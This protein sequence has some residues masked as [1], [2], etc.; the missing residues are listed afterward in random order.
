V[1]CACVRPTP[2]RGPASRAD[3]PRSSVRRDGAGS[4]TGT[5]TATPPAAASC[6][7]R[8]RT[9]EVARCDLEHGKAQLT[10]G[11]DHLLSIIKHGHNLPGV[12]DVPV[13]DLP[14]DDRVLALVAAA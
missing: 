5:A 14:F 1:R 7:D 8:I 3:Q 2:A 12:A 4:A 11:V 10:P 9:S 13:E 6:P